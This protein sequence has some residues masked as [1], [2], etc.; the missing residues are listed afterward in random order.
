MLKH[1]PTREV[2]PGSFAGIHFQPDGGDVP[3]FTAE[4]ME[5]MRNG[6]EPPA[7][8]PDAPAAAPEGS[9]AE[10]AAESPAA[11]AAEQA[12]AAKQGNPE[13]P[14]R[15]LRQQLGQ[16]QAMLADPKQLAAYLKA[17]GYDMVPAGQ[18]ANP[19][20]PTPDAAD[21]F[22][23]FDEP[24]AAALRAVVGPLQ[25]NLGD[26]QGK[27]A[28][29]QA[30]RAESEKH[31]NMLALEQEHPGLINNARAFDQVV[32]DA[33]HVDPMVKHLAMQGN[34]MT[35]PAEHGAIVQELLAKM[36]TDQ[37][38]QLLEPIIKGHAT[39]MVADKI[40][41]G[42]ASKQVPVTLGGA[43]PAR[44]NGSMKAMSDISGDEWRGMTEQER[45]HYRNG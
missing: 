13:V 37:V 15:V 16:A 43:L 25:Q 44:T 23:A 45:D 8:A 4:A 18:A 30:Q 28:L 17:N 22:A 34:R 2:R 39:A 3:A 11:E 19:D 10:E 5:A 26:L 41:G 24:T 32:P 29:E 42:N 9:P 21:P 1:P 6:Q 33:A 38:Q 40:T 27:L 12:P 14:L 36:P 20:T 35:D 31:A 7:P